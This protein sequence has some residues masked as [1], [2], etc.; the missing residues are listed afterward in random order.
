MKYVLK[1]IR[2]FINNHDMQ[3][4][5]SHMAIEQ[6]GQLGLGLMDRARANG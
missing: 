5:L 2:S 3:L 4:L 6:H 1:F